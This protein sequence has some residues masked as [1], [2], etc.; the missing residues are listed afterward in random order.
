MP[1]RQLVPED[2]PPGE[3]QAWG[4]IRGPAPGWGIARQVMPGA[5]SPNP[6]HISGRQKSGDRGKLSPFPSWLLRGG[7]QPEELEK[8]SW[9]IQI[10]SNSGKIESSPSR[11]WQNIERSSPNKILGNHPH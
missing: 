3:R 10:Q 9:D 6:G 8:G 11:S 7:Q 4:A 2:G 1:S 5:T